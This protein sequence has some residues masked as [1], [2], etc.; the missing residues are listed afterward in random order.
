M[1]GDARMMIQT[2]AA[3]VLIASASAACLADIAYTADH[4]SANMLTSIQL[5]TQSP[6]E[7]AIHFLP[8]TPYGLF[9]AAS[10]AVNDLPDLGVASAAIDIASTID[11][12][13]FSSSADI[14][15]SVLRQNATFVATNAAYNFQLNFALSEQTT[16][17]LS[18]S[19]WA[20]GEARSLLQIKALGSDTN[21]FILQARYSAVDHQQTLVLDPGAYTF[22]LLSH[23]GAIGWI[24]IYNDTAIAG[25]ELSFYQIPA[26][27]SLALLSIA[28]IASTRR[29]R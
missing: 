11:Q 13:G 24:D 16:F 17:E 1:Q 18:A 22:S 15:S 28:G 5:D 3:L 2:Q 12:S 8:D 19:L 20:Q 23:S 14:T 27:S 10:D 21:L 29:R 4:R 6:H 25:H 9:H 7:T 26:P